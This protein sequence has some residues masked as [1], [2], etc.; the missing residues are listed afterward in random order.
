MQITRVCFKKKKSNSCYIQYPHNKQCKPLIKGLFT[1]PLAC[2]F[3]L[4]CLVCIRNNM[5]WEIWIACF[6]SSSLR[7][8]KW[9]KFS[10]PM[11][12]SNLNPKTVIIYWITLMSTESTW[13][14]AHNNSTKY[15]RGS[16]DG[17]ITN[18]RMKSDKNLD[19]PS[20]QEY[21]AARPRS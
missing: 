15:R 5:C 8:S 14:K 13:K 2:C 7:E 6:S 19:S 10:S 21:A 11:S 18:N 9:G 3:I 4:G 16:L 20:F 12:Q 17:D 1:L